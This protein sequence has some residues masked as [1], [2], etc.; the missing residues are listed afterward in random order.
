M[1]SRAT[2]I[3]YGSVNLGL[4][5][6]RFFFLVTGIT[7]LTIGQQGMAI[8]I[9]GMRTVTGETISFTHRPVEADLG[10]GLLAFFMAAVTKRR[11]G[12]FYSQRFPSVSRMMAAVAC[13]V[14]KGFM[15]RF[16]QQFGVG[17]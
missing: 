7:E 9:R 14:I 17:R 2:P 5:Q 4:L 6:K 16:A 11:P 12:V 13:V 8:M 1:A 10:E 3:Y 15:D